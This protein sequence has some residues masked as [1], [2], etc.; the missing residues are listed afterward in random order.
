M[1]KYSQKHIRIA[2]KWWPSETCLV[3]QF[4]P[5]ALWN[6]CATEI[7]FP[8]IMLHGS[9]HHI[10]PSW[11][12]IRLYLILSPLC[13]LSPKD[14]GT[15]NFTNRH[16]IPWCPTSTFVDLSCMVV[17]SSNCSHQRRKRS[18]DKAYGHSSIKISSL[19]WA[20][21]TEARLADKSIWFTRYCIGGCC[22]WLV[23]HTDWSVAT[24]S[25]CVLFNRDSCRFWI[26]SFC[27]IKL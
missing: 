7:H 13:C 12:M 4:S 24:T 3:P 2:E 19:G 21:L 6:L 16:K 17:M 1:D 26:A 9:S 27:F 14:L 15:S 10:N 11:K 5:Q 23:S 8:M 22:S 18:R 25:P 20:S